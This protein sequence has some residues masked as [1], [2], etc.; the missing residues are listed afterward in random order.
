MLGSHNRD[1]KI[2]KFMFW[3][4]KIIFKLK[5]GQLCPIAVQQYQT[6]NIKD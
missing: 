1:E 6:N 5:Q 2:L 3:M 4:I